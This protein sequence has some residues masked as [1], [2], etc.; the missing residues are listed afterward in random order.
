MKNY[1]KILLYF[2][3][4]VSVGLFLLEGGFG[5]KIEPGTTQEE[6]QEVQG[7]AIK[8]VRQTN[9]GEGLQVPGTIVS[10]ETAAVS[11]KIMAA[12]TTVHVKKGSLVKKG[13]PLVSL[14][15]RQVR[16]YQ[17]QAV[18]Q[19]A[20][21]SAALQTL[22]GSIRVAQ[23]E[24][25]KAAVMEQQMKI[26][27]NH[28]EQTFLRMKK[29]YE[30]GAA[31]KQ[32][33]E[34]AQTEFLA[35]E[36]SWMDAGKGHEQA[37]ANLAVTQAKKGEASAQYQ[38][39]QAGY[40]TANVN[41]QEAV[42][43]S[44]FD[45]IVTEKMIDIGDMATPGVPLVTIERAPYSLEIDVDERKIGTVK[46]GEQLPVTI[47]AVQYKGKGNVLEITPRIDPASRKFRMK[48]SLP[49]DLQVTSGMYGQATIPGKAEDR[50]IL[51]QTAI[52]YWSQF[53]GVYVVD[54]KN[55]VHLTFV[56]IAPV[57]DKHVEVLSGLQI[58][59][60]IVVHSLEKVRDKV[61]VVAQK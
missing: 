9:S 53:T 49:T 32:D 24:V 5:A 27:M 38:Q 15:P 40:N 58:G 12:V 43:Y 44:P 60:R 55:V 26:K 3:L 14:D 29:L 20:G 42:L 47:D 18:A 56:N 13:D 23:T 21:A 34:N 46:V 11:A 48:V 7:V 2:V 35:H 6:Q 31:S 50:I 22:D 25:E 51:P 54:D 36:R 39:A 1:M 45:G 41:L 4:P 16:T 37:K 10:E 57:D 17:D 28:A 52:L 59:D 8:E 19:V 61:K 30:A 33:Y